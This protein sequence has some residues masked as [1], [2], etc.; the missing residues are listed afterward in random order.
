MLNSPMDFHA[1]KLS[2]LRIISVS[3]PQ[4]SDFGARASMILRADGIDAAASTPRFRL[5][6]I[7]FREF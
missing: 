3:Y 7:S 4:C 6:E 2:M 5:P 1:A